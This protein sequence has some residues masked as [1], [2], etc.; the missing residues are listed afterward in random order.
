[1]KII[2]LL[3]FSLITSTT[4]AQEPKLGTPEEALKLPKDMKALGDI[5]EAEILKMYSAKAPSGAEYC[6]YV[7]KWNGAEVVVPNML[8]SNEKT[9]GIKVGDTIQVMVQE[10]EM[11]FSGEKMHVVQFMFMG[12]VDKKG[13]SE[14]GN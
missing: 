7:I 3:L 2:T 4:F 5:I 1:M 11:V 10:I 8:S 6:G 14:E 9:K 13:K 12:S